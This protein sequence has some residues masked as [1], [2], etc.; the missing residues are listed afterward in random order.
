[1]H[2]SPADLSP[3]D[4]TGHRKQPD[5]CETWFLAAA[6]SFVGISLTIRFT[7]FDGKER[8]SILLSGNTRISNEPH[9]AF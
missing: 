1:M 2:P 8:A 5:D 4:C 7:A 9:P 3:A 6:W